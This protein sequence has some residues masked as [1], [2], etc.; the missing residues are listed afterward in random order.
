MG[1]PLSLPNL[2][3]QEYFDGSLDG[4]SI[5]GARFGRITLGSHRFDERT[6]HIGAEMP[7]ALTFAAA[8]LACA[9]DSRAGRS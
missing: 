6:G 4:K 8:A 9:M 5:R 1:R 2:I 3:G 7:R